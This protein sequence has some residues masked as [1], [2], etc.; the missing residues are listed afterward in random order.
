MGKNQYL[1]KLTEEQRERLN[2][3]INEKGRTER[4]IKR[5]KI[6]L[7]SDLTVNKNASLLQV[8]EEL[9]TSHTTVLTVRTEFHKLGLEMAVF[10]KRKSDNIT[11]RRLNTKVRE[12]LVALTNQEP[13][14]S[15]KRW[16][17]RLLASESVKRG[18]VSHI[19]LYTVASILRE[20]GV[21]LK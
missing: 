16:T 5:A 9:G 13:P 6:L 18:I 10:R 14:D 1:I 17:L 20:A 7:R 8:A 3:I 21:A 4:A 15:N 11:T 2:G 12:Q 19:S